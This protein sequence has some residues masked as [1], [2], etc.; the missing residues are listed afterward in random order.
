MSLEMFS[1]NIMDYQ[2]FQDVAQTV[3]HAN[4]LVLQPRSLIANY[5]LRGLG[6]ARIPQAPQLLFRFVSDNDIE[7]LFHVCYLCPRSDDYFADR[8]RLPVRPPYPVNTYITVANPTAT[9]S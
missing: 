1:G 8:T 4:Q 3:S 9:A 5:F 6:F 7:S 2:S